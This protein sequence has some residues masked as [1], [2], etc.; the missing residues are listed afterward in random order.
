MLKS[1]VPVSA[2]LLLALLGN[3]AQ[4]QAQKTWPHMPTPSEIAMM[5]DYCQ[6]KMGTNEELKQQWNQRMGPDKFVH[7]HHYCHGLKQ[8]NRYKLTFDAQQRR[9]ILQ[10]A[11][12]EFDYVVRNWPDDFYLKAEAKSQKAR[13]ESRLRQ[14]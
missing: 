13:A 6:A 1:T 7:L 3:P 9:F 11:I 4:A 12:G 2:A 5:P 8:M 14:P 10:T